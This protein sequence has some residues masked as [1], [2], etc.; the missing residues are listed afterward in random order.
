LGIIIPTDFH[1]FQR[2]W[3]HQPVI[4]LDINGHNY[5]DCIPIYDGYDDG[6]TAY[7]QPILHH[8]VPVQV[9]I[10]DYFWAVAPQLCKSTK[11]C[12]SGVDFSGKHVKTCWNT[13]LLSG[14]PIERRHFFGDQR[15]N[16]L[17]RISL[18]GVGGHTKLKDCLLMFREIEE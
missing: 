10:T 12:W 9:E 1:I 6:Y 2:G 7:W 4:D 18:Q 11:L 3:N 8:Q 13:C 17:R 15:S 5:R 14:V 16:V